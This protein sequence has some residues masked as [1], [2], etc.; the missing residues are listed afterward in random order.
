[1]RNIWAKGRGYLET[2]WQVTSGVAWGLELMTCLDLSLWGV[3]RLVHLG[4]HLLDLLGL[5]MTSSH[6]MEFKAVSDKGD[7]R[8]WS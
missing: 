7:S 6:N 5:Y 4:L 2:P 1:M 8:K 3:P